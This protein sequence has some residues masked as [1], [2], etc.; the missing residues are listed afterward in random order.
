MATYPGTAHPVNSPFDY[1]FEPLA[2]A[3]DSLMPGTDASNHGF[4]V[5]GFQ[6]GDGLSRCVIDELPTRPIQSLAES[7]LRPR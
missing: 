5:T 1:S 4:I 2:G 3:G 6:S 7:S